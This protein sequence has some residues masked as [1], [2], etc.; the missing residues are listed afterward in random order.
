MKVRAAKIEA[1]LL[2][3]LLTGAWPL[4]YL[5][6]KPEEHL[7][8]PTRSQRFRNAHEVGYRW[9]WVVMDERPGTAEGFLVTFDPR[10]DLDGAYG[11][12][13]KA[14]GRRL[15][16]FLGYAGDLTSALEAIYEV[17]PNG[18]PP[19]LWLPGQQSR[20]WV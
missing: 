5:G 4:E 18:K 15:G 20:H 11:L 8:A 17:G 2:E 13:T 14:H 12:A 19:N 16:E 10:C 9:L 1:R 6:W 7:V 3:D